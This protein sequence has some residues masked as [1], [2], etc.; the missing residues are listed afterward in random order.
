MRLTEKETVQME[1]VQKIQKKLRR[2][3]QHTNVGSK[4]TQ[5]VL[6]WDD[7]KKENYEQM[8]SRRNLKI[9]QTQADYVEHN[10]V[11]T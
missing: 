4:L 3:V 9:I 1:V 5:R 11:V 6:D 8:K 7:E 10:K 2:S